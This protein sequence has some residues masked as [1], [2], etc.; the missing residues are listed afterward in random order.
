MNTLMYPP[1]S[2]GYISYQNRTHPLIK[3]LTVYKRR[4]RIQMYTACP[5]VFD[6]SE[7]IQKRAASAK[8]IYVTNSYKEDIL[9]YIPLE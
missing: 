7:I 3:D 5:R 8:T 6:A 4:N 1:R 2:S 9:Y